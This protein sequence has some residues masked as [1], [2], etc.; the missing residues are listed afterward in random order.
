MKKLPELRG[1]GSYM[2]LG[3]QM[4][5]VTGVITAVGWWLDERTGRAPLFLI[6]FFVAGALGGM[7][8]VWRAVMQEGGGRPPRR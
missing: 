4:V 7:A 3:V 5:V 8:V 6:V 2:A 1:V